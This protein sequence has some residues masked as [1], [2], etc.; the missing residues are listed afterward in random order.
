MKNP[1]ALFKVP[2]PE[3]PKGGGMA[4]LRARARGHV[5]LPQV[6]AG[7]EEA[8]PQAYAWLKDALAMSGDGLDAFLAG[9]PLPAS[10]VPVLIAYL[11]IKAT[12]DAER[13]LLVSLASPPE[14]IV[15]RPE[16]VALKPLAEVVGP[17]RF[18]GA[19]PPSPAPAW[20]KRAGWA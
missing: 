5:H 2:E 14:R 3:P 1:L 10:K 17:P 16:P 12:Y 18:A 7:R 9:S 13:D 19:S 15:T 11:D 4:L 20:D 8:R 6:P